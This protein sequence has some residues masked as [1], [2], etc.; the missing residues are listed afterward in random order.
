MIYS[1]DKS[2]DPNVEDDENTNTK[3]D[4]FKEYKECNYLKE[5][6]YF[7]FYIDE[8]IV[9]DTSITI[10]PSKIVDDSISISFFDLSNIDFNNFNDLLVEYNTGNSCDVNMW[11]IDQANECKSQFAF[12]P[13]NYGCL[14]IPV[15]HKH[16]LSTTNIDINIYMNTNDSII[17]YGSAITTIKLINFDQ[18]YETIPLN[19]LAYIDGITFDGSNFWMIS[20][21]TNKIYQFSKAG[22]LIKEINSP[23]NYP[24]G[25][26]FD[27]KYLWCSDG[28]D[29]IFKINKDGDIINS[30]TVPTDFPGSLTWGNNKLWLSEYEG[31][32]PKIF[33]IDPDS[34]CILGQAVIVDSIDNQF[35]TIG[36]TWLEDHLIILNNNLQIYN[37]DSKE[38]ICNYP[39]HV[40]T[41]SDI[42]S[43]SDGLWIINSGPKDIGVCGYFLTK[44][45]LRDF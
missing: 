14:A 9:I 31:N 2:T 45:L 16:L 24:Q 43:D 12:A 36:L 7:G 8:E 1:C 21:G 32:N 37:P 41:T 22:E 5:Y 42:V 25:I 4:E 3:Y 44:F 20:N 15:H 23:E 28:T 11:L 39:M 33:S 17:T 6:S 27:G 10:T 40:I 30:F 19:G 26:T 38:I 34:S 18:N 29:Q 13:Q 35:N